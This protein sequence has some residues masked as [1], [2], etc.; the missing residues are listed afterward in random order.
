[1]KCPSK[2]ECIQLGGQCDLYASKFCVNSDCFYSDASPGNC[3]AFIPEN[4]NC[5][6]GGVAC[7]PGLSCY[8]GKCVQ[9]GYTQNGESCTQS[10]Q[11]SKGLICLGGQCALGRDGCVSEYLNCPYGQFCN[12]TD[13]NN[14]IC[15]PQLAIGQDC[16]INSNG[17]PYGSMCN[18]YS[19]TKS[20]CTALYSLG[21]GQTCSSTPN[22]PLTLSTCNPGLYCNKDGVC[23][24]IQASSNYQCLDDSY[25]NFSEMCVCLENSQWGKCVVKPN[26]D[27]H[28]PSAFK[29][30][31]TCLAKHQCVEVGNLV[32]LNSCAASKCGVEYCNTEGCYSLDIGETIV[33]CPYVNLINSLVC[34]IPSS[35]SSSN[36]TME[37]SLSSSL[38]SPSIVLVLLLSISIIIPF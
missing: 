4:G 35:S 32:N 27:A 38:S 23:T 13:I 15:S 25:C 17:C 24:T 6:S 18:Q 8:D 16:T 2:S 10:S 9:Y 1:M 37:P 11:C 3:T 30:Y 5:S 26:L 7:S 20:R 12:T 34:S 33:D 22:D 36:S 19:S 29:S 28:C 31:F 14:N 21:L